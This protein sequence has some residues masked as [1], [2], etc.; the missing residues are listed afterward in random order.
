M[1]TFCSPRATKW[2]HKIPIFFYIGKI[3]EPEKNKEWSQQILAP[4][5]FNGVAEPLVQLGKVILLPFHIKVR[6][7]KQFV[8]TLDNN[9]PCFP[10]CRTFPGLSS[11]KIKRW[12]IWWVSNQKTEKKKDGYFVNAMNCIEAVVFVIVANDFLGSNKAD[13]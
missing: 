12:C 2:I 3:A 9:G 7:I 5:S 4:R 6:I 8:K 13:H 1:W 11:K 10:I